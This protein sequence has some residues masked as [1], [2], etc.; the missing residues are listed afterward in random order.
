MKDYYEILDLESIASKDEI[1]KAYFK[2][3]RRYP[4]DRYEKEF[5]NIREAY[6]T[7]SNEKTRKEYDSI[8]DLSSIMK[9]NYKFDEVRSLVSN[10]NLRI[11]DNYDPATK[12]ING[13]WII[14]G[15]NGS[16][17]AMDYSVRVYTREEFEVWCREAGF[18]KVTT[19][20]EWNGSPYDENSEDMMVVA[21]K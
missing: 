13:R 21:E 12:R 17:R 10:R 3:V 11:I 9:G 4:P 15:D 16:E 19:Y 2:L 7:L 5:M 14:G 1:K 18:R 20:S 8:N 6:E